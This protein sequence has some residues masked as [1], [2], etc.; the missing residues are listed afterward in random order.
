MSSDLTS[1]DSPGWSAIR[2]A[3]NQRVVLVNERLIPSKVNRVW[4][5]ETDVRPVIVKRSLSGRGG[6]E[7]ELLG[8]A[9]ASGLDV[10]LPLHRS[11]DYLVL[12][13]IGGE[14]CD[15]LVNQL[16]SVEVADAVAVWLSRFHENMVSGTGSPLTMA[17]T[18]LSNFVW[19]DGAVYGLDLEDVV[20]GDPLEDLGR[21]VAT[22]LASE[23][24]FAPIKF[25]VCMHLLRAY[26]AESGMEAI[27]SVRPFVSRHLRLSAR[28]RPVFRKTFA[29]A[30]ASLESFGWPRLA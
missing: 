2:D 23:P 7:F 12:E 26:E 18:E 11:G 13:Y 19:L 24:M 25:D 21:L 4:V 22:V 5:V 28:A 15:S 14:R 17:D 9:R 29:E 8:R 6:H 30:A 1:L 16:F 3:L 10:P 20:E 27:E